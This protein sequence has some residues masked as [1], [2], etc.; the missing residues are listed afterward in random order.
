MSAV[1]NKTNLS[2]CKLAQEQLVDYFGSL[3]NP[4]YAKGTYEALSSPVNS[5]AGT[6]F[7]QLAAGDLRP[8]QGARKVRMEYIA[9]D[10]TTYDGSAGS[11]I[12]PCTLTG[13]AQ[14]RKYAD[15]E[16]GL[17]STP[18]ST[19]LT[20]ADLKAA[21]IGKEIFLGQWMAQ[22]AEKIMQD[23]NAQLV[24]KTYSLMS[25]YENGDSSITDPITLNIINSQGVPNMIAISAVN[26]AYRKRG[27]SNPIMVGGSHVE[28][29]IQSQGKLGQGANGVNYATITAPLFA[30]FQMDGV[31]NNSNTNLLTWAPGSIQLIEWYNTE[32]LGKIRKGS[33]EIGD[34]GVGYEQEASKVLINGVFFDMYMTWSCNKWVVGLQ[35]IVDVAD[36]PSDVVCEG[37][38]PAL[39]FVSGCGDGSCNYLTSGI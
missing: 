11:V 1:I 18:L 38:Y 2:I 30:D 9:P 16:V 24:A 29:L 3:A 27:Y 39:A 23:L 13:S 21:C 26:A 7:T 33:V 32:G 25:T 22:A 19:E 5:I 12:N 8:G 10:C 17:V 20:V 35:K 6:K 4:S 37:K 14:T 31:I 28:G 36:L 15:Y 34:L